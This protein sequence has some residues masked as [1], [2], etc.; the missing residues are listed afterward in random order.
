[1]AARGLPARR[2]RG[3]A[4]P[5]S[6]PQVTRRPA[7]ACGGA[8]DRPRH[9]RQLPQRA[10]TRLD[11]LLRSDTSRLPAR[12]PRPVAPRVHHRDRRAHRPDRH[13]PDPARRALPLRRRGRL[14]GRRHLARGHG[15]RVR[16]GPQRGRPAGDR[17]GERGTGARGPGR[18][19]AGPARVLRPVPP[20]AATAAPP[21]RSWWPG[22]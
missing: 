4:G 18:S 13:Q 12:R 22:C 6:H 7:A 1:M 14:G 3:R 9:R 10:L 8:S 15:I 11:R 21:P 19:Q 5:G 20:S 2:R 16:T 17:T